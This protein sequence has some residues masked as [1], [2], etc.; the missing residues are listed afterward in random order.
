VSGSIGFGLGKMMGWDVRNRGET[1]GPQI[2][3]KGSL[4]ETGVRPE[5]R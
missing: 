3:R 2:G 1:L 4:A 5:L